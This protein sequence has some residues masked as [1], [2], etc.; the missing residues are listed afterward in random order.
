MSGEEKMAERTGGET[1]DAAPAD[2]EEKLQRALLEAA[3]AAEWPYPAERFA[4]RGI[5]I[6]G[7]GAKYFPCTWVCVNM[8]RQLGC[9][10]PIEVWHL[11]DEEMDAEM[12]A[13]LMPQG[14]ELVDGWEVRKVHPVRV[15]LG[16]ELKAYALLH[17]RFAEVLLLDADNVAVRDPAYLFDA[18]EYREK[19]AVF[20]PDFG[21]L[22]PERP[23]WRLTGVAYRDEPE[24]ESGQILVDKARCWR[25]LQV[26][27]HLNE[28]SDFYYNHI[29]GDKETFHFAWRKLGQDYAMPARGI[30]DIEATMCQHDFA[31]ERIFQHRNFDKWN[32]WLGNLRVHGFLHEEQCL[33]LCE[34][35]AARWNPAPLGVRRFRAEKKSGDELAAAAQVAGR[36]FDYHRVG[37]DRRPMRLLPDGCIGEGAGGCEVYW[38]LRTAEDGKVR[39]EIFSDR[40]LTMRL[41]TNGCEIW[42]GR[43]LRH[44]CMPVEL[45]PLAEE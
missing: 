13:L 20:W 41:E 43:W 40:D 30:D 32:P 29:H 18:P 22:E 37:H 11:G 34:E 44:E 27:M 3:V 23:I 24:F 9:T 4:G 42:R 16:W 31:G 7:G 10:L 1:S 26:A 38:D 5:V 39:L 17:S 2:E 14:V 15:L 8:L 25:A 21:R 6:C 28:H 35:L 45:T 33:A 36:L 12:R 19:G